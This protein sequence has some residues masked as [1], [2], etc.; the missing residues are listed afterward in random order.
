[1]ADDHLQ[2]ALEHL[3]LGLDEEEVASS[4]ER[5]R[6]SPAFQRRAPMAPVWSR[7]HLEKE[8]AVA[9]GPQ[10]LLRDE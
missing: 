7:V 8:V 6:C 5:K 10:L 9:V 3:H 2:R 4:K 1:V